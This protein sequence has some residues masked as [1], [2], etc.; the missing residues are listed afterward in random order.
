M[1]LKGV[2]SML[3]RRL[4]LI[5]FASLGVVA[6]PV[7][8]QEEDED[9][10]IIYFCDVIPSEPLKRMKCFA[11]GRAKIDNDFDGKL[12]YIKCITIIM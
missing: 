4:L 1:S 6:A 3:N 8:A 9:R 11:S 12:S 10:D 7:A 5:T 2:C